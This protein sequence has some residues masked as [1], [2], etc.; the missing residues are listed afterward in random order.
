MGWDRC[1]PSTGMVSVGSGTVREKPTLGIPM[2]N[3]SNKLA[4]VQ[5]SDELR[6]AC[7]TWL[8]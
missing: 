4:V 3:L 7:H 5:N 2:A 6:S 1:I 8:D